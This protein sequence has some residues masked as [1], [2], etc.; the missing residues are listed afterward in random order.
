MVPGIIFCRRHAVVVFD[1]L[2]YSSVRPRVF[3]RSPVPLL[4]RAAWFWL[5]RLGGSALAPVST[6]ILLH[7]MIQLPPTMMH[8]HLSYTA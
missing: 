1:I 7:R 2:S 3:L 5:D 4:R 6:L 8:N